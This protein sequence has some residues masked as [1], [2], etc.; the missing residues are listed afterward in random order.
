MQTL[1]NPCKWLENQGFLHIFMSLVFSAFRIWAFPSINCSAVFVVR[2][3]RKRRRSGPERPA[4][5]HKREEE[6]GGYAGY[7]M[8]IGLCLGLAAGA[9][10]A[11]H[12]EK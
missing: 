11:A 5:A 3:W 2:L 8:C 7:G 6:A 12:A 4:E 1:I 10:F 9:A